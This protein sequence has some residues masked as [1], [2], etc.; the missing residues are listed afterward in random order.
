M[1]H[2][3]RLVHLLASTVHEVSLCLD[4]EV[5]QEESYEEN[6]RY[7]DNHLYQPGREDIDIHEHP[8]DDRHA[9]QEELR[10]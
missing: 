5:L 1:F 3:R 9:G 7:L 2:V 10:H 8:L 4:P 6:R